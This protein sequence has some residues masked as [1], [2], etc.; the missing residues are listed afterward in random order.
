MNTI[1]TSISEIYVDE[2]GILHIKIIESANV[3]LEN[4]KE[5]YNACKVLLGNDKVLILIDSR[6]KYK[7]SKEAQIY[8]ASNN[9]PL[10]RI[11]TAFLVDSF[12]SRLTAILYIWF[13]KPV[14]PTKSF[15]SKEKATKWLKS[16]YI[17]PGTPYIKHKKRK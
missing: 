14:I 17:M 16:F 10:N 7:F 9:I 15:T 5:N 13:K 6:V 3:T 8:A 2:D 4:I 11:A 1:K 12:I